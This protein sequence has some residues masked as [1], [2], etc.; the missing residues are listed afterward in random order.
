M[1][2]LKVERERVRKKRV[3]PDRD[4][5]VEEVV[6]FARGEGSEWEEVEGEGEGGSD[7]LCMCD[8]D[9]GLR[10][11]LESLEILTVGTMLNNQPSFSSPPC[12]ESSSERPPNSS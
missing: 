10:G 11:Q 9:C 12:L 7:G 3:S 1:V 6:T 4:C 2:D 8:C 5:P